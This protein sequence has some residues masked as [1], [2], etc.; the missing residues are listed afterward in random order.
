[1]IEAAAV[2]PFG[3][4]PAIIA[5]ARIGWSRAVVLLVVNEI[6]WFALSAAP[7]FKVN[8][9]KRPVVAVDPVTVAPVTVARVAVVTATPVVAVKDVFASPAVYVAVPKLELPATVETKNEY[10]P[11]TSGWKFT[12]TV[13]ELAGNVAPEAFVR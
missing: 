6:V 4:V 5:E 7:E 8:F 9:I 10:E 3:V 2:S 13:P 1:V 11:A 12:N